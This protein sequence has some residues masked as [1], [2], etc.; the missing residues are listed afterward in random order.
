MGLKAKGGPAEPS[1]PLWPV[2]E[3]RE[4][5]Y[6][7]H[8]RSDTPPGVALP[9]TRPRPAH[10]S[11]RRRSPPIN[12]SNRRTSP[13]K[14]NP[15]FL[16]KKNQPSQLIL[17]PLLL[18]SAAPD[19]HPPPIGARQKR[20]RLRRPFLGLVLLLHRHF[21]I[22]GSE[23]CIAIQLSSRFWLR[24]LV[25]CVVRKTLVFLWV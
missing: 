16:Q 4:A 7:N 1:S 23:S 21:P 25:N 20:R 5:H 11:H 8:Q 2:K 10:S 14:I 15:P 9:P 24:L 3:Q 6:K 13:L 19:P 22:L 12:Q 17:I 18:H